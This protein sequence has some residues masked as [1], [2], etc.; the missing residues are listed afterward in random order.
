M[1]LTGQL[2]TSRHGVTFCSDVQFSKT[3]LILCAPPKYHNLTLPV[4][5]L[6]IFQPG[7][8]VDSYI[9]VCFHLNLSGSWWHP[10][11]CTLRT[12]ELASNQKPS[13]QGGGLLQATQ[14]PSPLGDTR[15]FV[16]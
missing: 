5:Y 8:L 9:P 15:G 14:N 11:E 12:G 1:D 16:S 4:T 13:L 2:L 10:G 7:P 6:K 3:L